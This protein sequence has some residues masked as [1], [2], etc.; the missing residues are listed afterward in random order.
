[1]SIQSLRAA[2][3][4]P[5]LAAAAGGLLLTCAFPKLEL[6][7]VAFA[8]LVPL[9]AAIAGR[10]PAVAFRLGFVFGL[11]HHL[12][13]L[14]WV[15]FT[16]RT[17][18]QLPLY[19]CVPVLGL[20][21]AYLALYPAVFCALTV[22]L[23]LPAPALAPAIG[24]LWTAMEVLRA[25]LFTGFPWALLGYSQYTRLALIQIADITGVYGVSFLVATVNAGVWIAIQAVAGRRRQTVPAATKR[26]AGIVLLTCLLLWG[27]TVG[28]GKWRLG[29]TEARMAA[30]EKPVVAVVQGNIEQG[31]KWDPKFQV[32]S[33]DRY[34]RLSIEALAAYPDLVVWP[35]TATPFYLFDHRE[36]TA[37]VVDFVRSADTNFLIGSPSYRRTDGKVEYYNSAYL[38]G[39]DGIS[40]GRYDKVHLVPFGEYVP[41]QR[42]LPFIGKMVAQV[43]DFRSG[44]PGATLKCN[45]CDLGVQICYEIIFPPLARRMTANGAD[46]LVNITNDAWFG[47]S[48]APYQHF[49]MAVFRAVENRRTLVRAANTGISALIAP[50]GRVLARTGLGVEASLARPAPLLSGQTVYT[51]WGDLWAWTCLAAAA[52]LTFAGGACCQRGRR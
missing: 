12:T 1:M 50:T 46:L 36:L 24:A 32:A 47:F 29:Q 15:V 44:S 3:V 49:S 34:F 48:G 28:Y 5:H 21:A 30:A 17:Y 42:F 23:R 38:L 6:S 2:D 16:M 20:L 11:A 31:R 41:L 8:A 40:R 25:T 52:I 33:L 19:L 22:R 35:E 10:R 13:L 51:R 39:P 37:P 18:G 14:S 26:D 27:G 43:G 4:V 7:A 45:G 9:L